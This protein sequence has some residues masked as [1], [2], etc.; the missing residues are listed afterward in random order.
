LDPGRRQFYAAL[1]ARLVAGAEWTFRLAKPAPGGGTL[2]QA[3]RSYHKHTGKKHPE[4]AWDYE[5]PRAA[6]YLLEWFWELNMGRAVSQAGYLGLSS[7]EIVAWA[8]LR[9]ISLRDWELDAIRQLD[10]KFLS[11]MA[12]KV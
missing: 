8:T 7:V 6:Q 12:E 5:V 9:R 4:D 1:I 2:G 10:S 11:V 3:F